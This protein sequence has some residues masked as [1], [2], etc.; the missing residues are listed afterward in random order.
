MKMYVYFIFIM[1]FI[2]G[3]CS[4]PSSPVDYKLD[5]SINGKTVSYFRNQK[6]TLQLDLHADGG[7]QWDYSISDTNVV[8]ID[9]T[10][11]APKSGNP[12]QIG[13]I[14][15]ETFFFCT[16]Q[17]GQ[18]VINLIEQRIWEPPEVPPI[19]SLS[20]TVIVTH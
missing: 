2:L 3:N 4:Q 5:S 15:I 18:S 13:G 1:S 7:Y 12:N 9:S 19:N 8:R 20:F 14:T 10:C 17:K 6:F 11:F 16:L